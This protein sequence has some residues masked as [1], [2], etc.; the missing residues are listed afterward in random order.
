MLYSVY[1]IFLSFR[2]HLVQLVNNYAGLHSLFVHKVR[3]AVSWDT[4]ALTSGLLPSSHGEWR[5]A[6][7]MAD[8]QILL[9]T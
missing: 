1:N 4:S 5:S 3:R 7:R 9:I 8:T 6:D 2:E